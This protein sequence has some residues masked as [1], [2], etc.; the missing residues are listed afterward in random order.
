MNT[1]I[2]FASFRAK[3]ARMLLKTTHKSQIIFGSSKI[4]L[5]EVYLAGTEGL[6]GEKVVYN[7]Y[8][9]L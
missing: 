7:I 3:D 1:V 8:N 9:D 4:K 5:G 6:R 2:W